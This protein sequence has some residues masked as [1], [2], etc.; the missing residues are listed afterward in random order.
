MARTLKITITPMARVGVVIVTYRSAP[1]IDPCL[2]SLLAASSQPLDVVVVDNASDDNS[3]ALAEAHGVRVIR[4]ADNGGYG[5][6]NNQ[7]IAAL[8]EVE[9]VVLANPDTVW[10][11]GSIDALSGLLEGDASIG[12][13]SPTLVEPNGLPQAFVERDLRLGSVLLAMTRLRRPIRPSAPSFVDGPLVEVD[14]LH[15]AAAMVPRAT[16]EAVGGF[17]ERF[18]LFGEDAD[19][20]RRIREHG[21]RVVV[22]ANVRVT[23]I[24]GASFEASHDADGSAALRTRALATYLDKYQGTTAR[25]VFGLV[26]ALVYGLARHRGQAREAWKAARR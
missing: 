26:G 25:R 19:L 24:G 9:V 5:R 22:A 7:G 23:H 10:P 6:A 2:T 21:Q 18:F 13:L 1:T 11:A 3:A 20:C 16:A 17:D 8:G 4:R 15:P 12:L 14:W